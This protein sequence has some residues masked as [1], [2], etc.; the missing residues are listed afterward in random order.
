M[1]VLIVFFIL[2]LVL[3]NNLNSQLINKSKTSKLGKISDLPWANADSLKNTIYDF[4]EI[5]GYEKIYKY[6]DNMVIMQGIGVLEMQMK[7]ANIFY[8]YADSVF[9]K[10][11]TIDEANRKKVTN[12]AFNSETS[13]LIKKFQDIFMSDIF[14]GDKNKYFGYGD[15]DEE[16]K[17][18]LQAIFEELRKR[19]SLERRKNMLLH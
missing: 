19:L 18:R 14:V 6:R 2:I 15:F 13:E 10:Y 1:K 11:Y 8:Y 4:N 17:N 9:Y 7:I 12:G 16:T 5:K 3:S